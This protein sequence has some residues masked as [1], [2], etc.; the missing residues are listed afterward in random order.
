MKNVVSKV[1]SG[2]ALGLSSLALAVP[3]IQQNSVTMVQQGG[4]VMV[5]YTLEG[6]RGIVTVD[7]QTNGVSIGGSHLT[8]LSGDVNRL[9][10]PGAR[11]FT[12]KPFKAWEGNQSSN[13]TA[14]VSAWATNCPPD[15][16]AVSL[17][18]ANTVRYY[19]DAESVPGGVTNDLYKTDMLLM[20]K[21][22]AANVEWRMGS[23]TTE[24]GRGSI[25]EEPHLVTLDEDYYIGVYPVTQR[26]YAL[27]V[28]GSRPSYFKLDAD[29]A[30]RPVESVS[31]RMARG[32]IGGSYSWPRDGHAVDGDS[33]FG[34]LNARVGMAGFD[35]PTEA[36]WE[37]ACRA[38]C[39][40]A[41]YSGEELS[42][43][44][45]S[46]N[47]NAVGRYRYNGGYTGDDF[48]A[49]PDA[50]CTAEHGTAKVGSYTPNAWGLYD[51]LGNVFEWVLDAYAENITSCDPNT[52]P[53]D[54]PTSGYRM[55]RGGQWKSAAS[56]CRSAYRDYYI[57]EQCRSNVGIRAARTA[58]VS[59]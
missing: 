28:N 30:T 22:P 4:T 17:V 20:R 41:L 29:Y 31:Y 19:P 10:E 12:W 53:S 51:M 37:F 5:N 32:A 1:V 45:T 54:N 34:R 39:G 21:I 52:G 15:Y 59:R 55:C 36:Q 18:A 7:I 16:M 33:F 47:L 57:Y 8:Y 49:E 14:V 42:N 48:S 46:P 27:V 44:T 38:G 11:S 9:V 56:Q 50:Q 6:E 43:A 58:V 26:Q 25:S 40:A 13:A 3:V 23:P 24:T 35:L 2:M